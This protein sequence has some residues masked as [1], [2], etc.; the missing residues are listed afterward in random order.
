MFH[1]NNILSKL[2]FFAGSIAATVTFSANAAVDVWTIDSLSRAS[3]I[4]EKPD[5]AVNSISMVTAKHEYEG[6]QIILRSSANFTVNS[7][8]FTD[9]S[10]AQGDLITNDNFKFNFRV[11]NNR[12]NLFYKSR[13]SGCWSNCA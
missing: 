5:G 6:G 1:K 10:S 2:V 13:L 9:L 4:Q 8:S 12:G 11:F 7:V 3:K